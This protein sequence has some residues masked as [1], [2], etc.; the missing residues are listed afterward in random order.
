MTTPR[1]PGSLLKDLDLDAGQF[2][3]LVESARQLKADKQAG[4]EQPRLGGREIVL[5]FE[6][7]STRTRC[8]FEVAARDQ[9]A[10][11]TYLGP[12]GSHVGTEES[13]P[14]TARVLGRMFDGIGFRGFAQQTVEQLAEF[15]G[16]PVWNGLTDQWHP[17]QSLADILTMT[18]NHPGPVTDIA[19][20]FTGD[21]RNNVARSLLVTGALLGMDVRIAAPPALTPPPDVVSA[22]RAAAEHSGARVTVTDDVHAGVRGADFVYTDVWVSMGEPAEDWAVRVP[23]MLPYRVTSELLESTGKPAPGSCTACPAS[24]TPRPSSEPG[25][26]TSSGWTAPRS[27]R[28][29]SSPSVP[30]SSSRP[31]TGCI[32]SRPC[33]SGRWPTERRGDHAH[34]RRPG[35]QRAAAAR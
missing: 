28:R 32:P 25:C 22:A 4:T 5:V 31:R 1:Q 6:K 20:C 34:R 18:E 16:V 35:R 19:Y 2:L 10:G 13:I 27:P 23:E 26:T 15:A 29:S 12:D 7:N 24:T 21:G 9:G 11:I 3:S 14:D 8:A 30:W 33:S 17:T